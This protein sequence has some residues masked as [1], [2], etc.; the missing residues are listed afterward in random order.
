MGT[1]SAQTFILRQHGRC[2]TQCV[3]HSDGFL[4][5][6]LF[7]KTQWRDPR[8]ETHVCCTPNAATLAAEAANEVL[9]SVVLVCGRHIWCAFP[10]RATLTWQACFPS[11][12]CEV[13]DKIAWDVHMQNMEGITIKPPLPAANQS[14]AFPGNPPHPPPL[15]SSAA[16]LHGKEPGGDA[17]QCGKSTHLSAVATAEQRFL[18]WDWKLC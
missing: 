14:A 7:L 17:K 13:T 9:H 2:E 3:S 12:R 16:F 11:H 1:L 15:L 4:Q 5:Q 10:A 6:L 18:N 8:L